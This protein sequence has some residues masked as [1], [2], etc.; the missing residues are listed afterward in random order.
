MTTGLAFPTLSRIPSHSN[1]VGRAL[2]LILLSPVTTVTTVLW[3]G[4]P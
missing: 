4:G 1:M 3:F 2:S